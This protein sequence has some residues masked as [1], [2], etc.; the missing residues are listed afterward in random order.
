ML[1]EKRDQE[2]LYFSTRVARGISSDVSVGGC[3]TFFRNTW[4]QMSS[5]A[6]KFYSGV[7]GG[8][9]SIAHI[10]FHV[11]TLIVRVIRVRISKWS[12]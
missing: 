4:F 6:E 11:R 2:K 12:D 8:P 7:F 3:L 9:E 1:E 10:R 5:Q